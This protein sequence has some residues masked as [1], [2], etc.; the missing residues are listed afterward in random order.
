MRLAPNILI[1]LAL[2]APARAETAPL[3]PPMTPAGQDL[4]QRLDGQGIATGLTYAASAENI[5]RPKPPPPPDAPRLPGGRV[6]AFWVLGILAVALALWVRFGGA[7]I[8]TRRAP[9][10]GASV[11]PPDHWQIDRHLPAAAL[12]DQIAA[13]QDRSAALVQ[14]LRHCLLQAAEESRTRLA[15]ADTER[16]AFARLPGER[17]ALAL[18]LHAAELAHYGGRPVGDAA[19]AEALSAGRDLL[20]ARHG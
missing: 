4:A 10:E 19:F 5:A 14:L 12:I 9:Q 8:L 3:D 6:S 11:E 17:P 20:G 18:I 13:M 16:E 2:A 15:R 1:L 7:G